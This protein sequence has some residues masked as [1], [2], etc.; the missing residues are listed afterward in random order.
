MLTFLALLAAA[1]AFS[2]PQGVF[3]G[4]DATGAVYTFSFS[5]PLL[6]RKG[7]ST[8]SGVCQTFFGSISFSAG[9]FATQRV[10][11]PAPGVIVVTYEGGASCANTKSARAT[12]VV[13]SCDPK[14]EGLRVL[15]IAEGPTCQYTIAAASAAA[16]G[17]QLPTC[18]YV[19]AGVEHDLTSLSTLSSGVLSNGNSYTVSL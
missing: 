14:T 10:S 15:S 9:A 12:T 5:S 2:L 7:T 17:A 18:A 8:S 3:N 6:C 11:V 16:C 13:V 19:V 4:T 1:S